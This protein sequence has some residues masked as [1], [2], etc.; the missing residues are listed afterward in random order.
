MPIGHDGMESTGLR[1]EHLGQHSRRRRHIPSTSQVVYCL[2]LVG[3]QIGFSSFSVGG[4]LFAGEPNWHAE[5]GF[6]WRPLE[7]PSQGKSGFTLLSPS[8][9]GVGFTNTLTL[10]ERETNRVLANGSGVAAGDFDGDGL[11][12]LFFCSLN[13][14]NRLYRN[15]GHWHFQDVT[16]SS[17][18]VVSNKYCR[19]AVF[20]DING[21]G[22]PD[23]LVATTGEGVKVFINRDQGHFSDETMAAG[24]TT[25]YGS[26]TLTLA[27][28]DGDGS[29]DLYVVNNRTD[30]IRDH[31][32]LK[33]PMVA[34]KLKVPPE[35]KDRIII[36]NGRLLEFGE[37]SQ[38]YWNDGHGHFRLVSWTNGV[39]S[40]EIGQRLSAPPLDWGLTAAFRDV[41]GDGWPDLYVCNDY[42]TPDRFWLNDGHGRFRLAPKLALRNTSGSS[43]GIDFAD[44]NRS[45]HLDFLVVDMLSRDPQ[46]RRRQVAAQAHVTLPAG[47]IDNRP[48]FLRN[49]LQMDR[50]DGTYAEI[51]NFAGI[52]ATDWSWTPVFMDVDLDGYPDLLV[53]A[54]HVQDVQDLDAEDRI[55]AEKKRRD[56][57]VSTI[58]NHTK[59]I[60]EKMVYTQFYPPLDMPIAAFHNLHGYRFS[61][62]TLEWGTEFP[63]VHHAMAVADFDGD[64]DLDLVVNNL[65]APSGLYRNNTTAPRVAVR[66]AG[67]S[68][69]TQGI[70]ARVTLHG[71]GI[72]D[73]TD[74]IM[75]GGKYMS[76]SDVQLMFAAPLR[77][78]PMSLEVH[79]RSGRSTL[80]SEVQAN[81]MYEVVEPDGLPVASHEKPAISP[82]LFEAAS[83]LLSHTHVDEVFNDFDRQPA[84][85]RKLSQ[86]GPGVAWGDLFGSGR[87][88][89][90]VGAGR[91][92][93]LAAFR[94]IDGGKFVRDTTTNQV[95]PLERDATMALIVGSYEG[96]SQLLVG[97]SNY[98][99]GRTDGVSVR[100]YDIRSPNGQTVATAGSSAVGALAMADMDG[101]GR[102][103]LF[104][105]GRVSISGYPLP[106]SS[107]VFRG[108]AKGFE[109]DKLNSHKMSDLG[110]VNGA[111]WTDLDG[112][113]LPEL[114]A[115]CE[116]G[117][118]RIFRDDKNVIKEISAEW[119]ML[120]LT[121]W[122]TGVAAGDFDGDGRMDLLVGNWGRIPL[123][124]R[125]PCSPSAC[126]LAIFLGAVEWI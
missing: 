67:R 36:Q 21:D 82:T 33:L 1:A 69:N 7:V 37:P 57:S 5:S 31:G 77:T 114:V 117:P 49:T 17:G 93:T 103:D 85:P 110:M 71:A 70:G 27:D 9:T 81:R 72:P 125:A 74:E 92:G 97:F 34:G 98:E 45:G 73:Q 54:G 104:V 80:I 51:A 56:G 53:T 66:L 40:T 38:F 8:E 122:W 124:T 43:M 99:D 109:L 78:P 48:Q 87:D 26:V 96:N 10:E 105:A 91:G 88:D 119:G 108:T 11:P 16:A 22:R 126:T 3:W 76:G 115:A 25:P 62:V 42:W 106:A 75:A 90:V 50:G 61:D 101:D 107:Q 120:Q 111:I 12:D 28:V 60:A 55:E 6:R 112:D 63:A 118:I 113:G 4:R 89:L 86:L 95:A 52:P 102:L 13:G 79:W 15:L 64:G 20:A 94:N 23:L 100:S 30:D 18:I 24:T 59:F 116:W 41:N 29:L 65:G 83:R 19:G 68:P 2:L 32:E 121:G 47:V 58:G 46:M 39:F 123:T 44:I 14:E 35:L 84:L